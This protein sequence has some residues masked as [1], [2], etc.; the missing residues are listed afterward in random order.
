MTGNLHADTFRIMKDT[1]HP[2][3]AFAAMHYL[4]T[5]A[6]LDLLTVYGAAPADESLT[7]DY[8]ASLEERYP[9]G[10]AWDVALAG[11][12]FAD[13][14][15]HESATPGWAEYK[16]AMGVLQSAILTDPT[17]D[18]EAAIAGLETQLTTIFQA[19]LG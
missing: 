9:Q 5:D 15:N 1:Q 16:E 11:A 13:V 10:V 8:I 14:P 7:A 19:N 2:D 6:A 18:L 3:E 4:V 12:D 17:L